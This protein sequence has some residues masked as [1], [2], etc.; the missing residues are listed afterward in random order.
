LTELDLPSTMKTHFSNAEDLLNFELTIT[1][2]E[3]AFPPSFSS[4][5]PF[6]PSCT[7]GFLLLLSIEYE[8]GMPYVV[9][10]RSEADERRHTGM[11][12]GGQFKFTVAISNN[13]P[14]EPPKVKCVPKV[15]SLLL[16]LLFVS[17]PS[18]PLS[19]LL[20]ASSSFPLT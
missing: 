15:R 6:P 19:S 8:D 9:E 2:D 3:G 18:S 12:K 7:S 1:P 14:H 11:Y 17:L 4:F 5:Y 16:P 20:S 10:R 13:Y